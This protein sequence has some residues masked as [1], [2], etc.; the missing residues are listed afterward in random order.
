MAKKKK[1]QGQLSLKMGLN[2]ERL[3]KMFGILCLFLALYLF[4]AFTSYLFTWQADQD[5]VLRFTWSRVWISDMEMSNWLG[6]L[7]AIVSNM[8][9]FWGFGL[10]S[11][12]FVFLISKFGLGL[13][14]RTSIRKFTLTLRYSVIALLSLSVLFEFIFSG[15]AF[16]WGGAFGEKVAFWLQNFVGTIGL[17]VLFIFLLAGAIVWNV[18][19]NFNEL[20]FSKAISEIKLYFSDL[21]NGRSS[22][23]NK[24]M[25]TLR[26]QAQTATA[27]RALTP[28]GNTPLPPVEDLPPVPDHGEGTQ[29]AFELS[30]KKKQEKPETLKSGEAELEIK[31]TDQDAAGNPTGQDSMAITEGNVN[32]LE[33]YDPTLELSFYQHPTTGLLTDY[34]AQRIDI[35]RAELEQNK[36]QI[37]ETLLNYKIEIVKI[38]ATIGP[39]V[40]LYEIV[41]A[42]GVR[43]SKIKNLEDDIALS[44]AALGIRIIA[45]I[46]GKGTIGIEVPNKNKQ[47]VS[48][49]RGLALRQIQECQNGFADRTR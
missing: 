35:D 6:R 36:D 42:P 22:R 16:P 1:K 32:H 31:Q 29:L 44:L 3:P 10:P 46:P 30:E 4:I 18:N 17:I 40:T 43:I 41:P 47:V 15:S 38:R 39:T 14:R 34:S 37:I 19:P 21:I 12:I 8:F 24:P 48:M 23:K 49:R 27:P 7:G 33:P 25:D 26:P 20:T 11:Y 2:D 9:F 13:I 28:G 45:P 5:R